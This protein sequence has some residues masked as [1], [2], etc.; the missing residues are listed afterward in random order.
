MC[1]KCG[2]V[3][4]LVRTIPQFGRLPEL[5]AYYCERCREAET[6]EAKQTN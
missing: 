5:L 4:T 6:L 1:P 2:K 3:M